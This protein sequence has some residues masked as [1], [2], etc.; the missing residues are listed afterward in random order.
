MLVFESNYTAVYFSVSTQYTNVADTPAALGRVAAG[1]QS[2]V[3]NNV[4]NSEKN[5]YKHI[6]LNT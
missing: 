3:K 1:M 4:M 6:T 5:R 2:C